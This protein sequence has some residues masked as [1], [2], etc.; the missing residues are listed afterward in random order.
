[1]PTISSYTVVTDT[2]I[3]V[4]IQEINNLIQQG[5]IPSGG[6]CKSAIK[7]KENVNIDYWFSQAMVKPV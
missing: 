7:I 3:G 6:I 1:M 5:W 2:N 4:L